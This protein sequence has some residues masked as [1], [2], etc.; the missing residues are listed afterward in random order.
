MVKL[1]ADLGVRELLIQAVE[2][3]QTPFLMEGDNMDFNTPP[4]RIQRYMDEATAEAAATGVW[5]NPNSRHDC[6]WASTS[7]QAG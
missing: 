2:R 6:P 4:E 7:A 3:R 1:C 5:F